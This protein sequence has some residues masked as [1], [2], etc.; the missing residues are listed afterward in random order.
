MHGVCVSLPTP[1]GFECA[2][3]VVCRPRSEC[4][5]QQCVAPDA[6]AWDLAWRL[7]LDYQVSGAHPALLATQG[8]LYLTACGLPGDAD[9]DAGAPDASVAFDGGVACGLLS[10][11]A[12]GYERFATRSRDGQEGRLISASS[13]GV[14]VEV[15]GGVELRSRASG[16]RLAVL[17]GAHSLARQADGTF[18]GPRSVPDGG[19]ELVFWSLDGGLQ[20]EPLAWT[21]GALVATDEARRLW[22]L[23]GDGGVLWWRERA[24]DGG[25]LLTSVAVPTGLDSLA[26]SAGRALLGG[27]L[28]VVLATDGGLP[29]VQELLDVDAGPATPLPREQLLGLGM[30]VVFRRQCPG[31]AACLPDEEVTVARVVD[32][33]QGSLAWEQEVMP[34][35]AGA[36][37][38]DV[39]L[40]DQLPGAIALVIRTAGDGGVRTSLQVFARGKQLLTCPLP[41][42][43]KNARSALLGPG[44]LTVLTARGDGGVTLVALPLDG[45]PLLQRGWFSPEGAGGTRQASP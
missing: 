39:A 38:L 45:L 15:A 40:V 18:A 25:G 35:G 34:G 8:S 29:L 36:T 43:A 17:E 22:A 2:P 31:P 32:S 26:V 1:E 27:H 4:H 6:G 10:Y 14:A 11:T 24:A 30:G 19:A 13:A 44:Q 23:D 21:A 3:A 9:A 37:L 33:A 7:P 12:S 42:E 41:D 16:S 5:H 20:Q 28:L